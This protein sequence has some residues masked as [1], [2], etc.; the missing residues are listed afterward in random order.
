MADLTRPTVGLPAPLEGPHKTRGRRTTPIR[1]YEIVFIVDPTLSD[2]ELGAIQNRLTE[3]A[4]A[5]GAEV[6]R[7]APWERRR[8]AYPIAGRQ[9]GVYILA[10]VRAEPAAVREME[11]QLKLTETVLRHLVVRLE[12]VAQT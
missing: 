11:N 8:L 7:I 9:D 1:D 2:E 6:K 4:T 3:L 10:H 5:R 12:E